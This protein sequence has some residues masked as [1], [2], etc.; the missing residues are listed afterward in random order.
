ME[1]LLLG[2]DATA[3]IVMVGLVMGGAELVKRLFAKDW[4]AAA[5]IAVCGLIGAGAGFALGIT[6]L[7]GLA[8]GMAA[9]GYYSLAQRIGM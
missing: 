2:L 5:I 9:T 4:K 6:A 8:F 1:E 3:A 7:Q